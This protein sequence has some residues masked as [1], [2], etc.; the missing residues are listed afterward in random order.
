[1]GVL[2]IFVRNR[3]FWFYK[4][5]K[6]YSESLF[7]NHSRLTGIV[8]FD[9]PGIMPIP[10]FFLTLTFKSLRKICRDILPDGK[11]SKQNPEFRI[12]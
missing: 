9:A 6:I 1:M 7:L 8:T 3:C 2:N 11:K 5:Y 4:S 12:R 10:S